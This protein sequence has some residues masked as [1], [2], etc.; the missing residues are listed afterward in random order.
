MATV[1]EIFSDSE[2]AHMTDELTPAKRRASEIA[3][4]EIES[5]LI[6]SNAER[7]ALRDEQGTSYLTSLHID[8]DK[9]YLKDAND[10]HERMDILLLQSGEHTS[11]I[12]RDRLELAVFA[13]AF[14][15]SPVPL[16]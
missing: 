9:D 8:E 6:G 2:E 4:E 14:A 15:R 7:A 11:P 13:D 3:P 10:L 5:Q 1:E 16:R 12:R